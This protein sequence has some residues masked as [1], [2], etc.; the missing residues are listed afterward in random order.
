MTVD[1]TR[2]K[3]VPAVY[4]LL[5]QWRYAEESVL[6]IIAGWGRCACDWED[7]LA[8]CHHVWL[9]AEIVDAMRRRLTMYPG[10][11]ADPPVHRVFQQAMDQ[12]IVAPSWLDAMAGVHGVVNPALCRGYAEYMRAAHPV[13]DQPTLELLHRVLELKRLQAAWYA[14]FTKRYPHVIEPRY[15]QAVG[16]RLS[17]IGGFSREIPPDS[18]NAQPCGKH[19]SFRMGRTPGRVKDWDRAPNIM[20]M[21]ELDWCKSV[22]TRRLFFMI[23]YCWEMGVAEQQLQWIY[24]ADFMPWEFVYAEARHMWDESRHGNSGY[25][26]LRDFGLD[27]EHFGYSSYGV[28]GEGMLDPMTPGDVYEAFYG[29]TQIAETGYFETKRYCFEDF[30]EAE[31][32]RSAEMMQ[33]D[34]IDETSHV[35]YGRIWLDGMA[36]R[37]GVRED[38]RRRGAADR[39][40]A[41]SK[42]EQRVAGYRAIL[43]GKQ[44]VN[45]TADRHGGDCVN[46]GAHVKAEALRDERAWKHYRWLLDELRG[47]CPMAHADAAPTRPFLPM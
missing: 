19:T 38:Y 1:S 4:L 3:I 45:E 46:P 33:F 7:K 6:R 5:G 44:P 36:E 43:A 30:R 34:I 15:L 37:A 26:R 28:S 22:E 21:I 31:D 12:V 8:V 2:P 23:G 41:R 42:A 24:H 25:S 13:H 32:E 47:Q 16:S 9:Q 17:E 27:F 29:V 35:E 39:A 10:G 18:P 20:P 11:K 40:Q 14:G